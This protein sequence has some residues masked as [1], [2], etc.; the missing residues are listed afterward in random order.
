MVLLLT[1]DAVLLIPMLIT[2]PSLFGINGVWM[3]QPLSNLFAFFII[4]FW[5]MR[6][7]TLIMNKMK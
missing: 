3:A 5:K 4:Y 7:F 2:L 6:E 1:R